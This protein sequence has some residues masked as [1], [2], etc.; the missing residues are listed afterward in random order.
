MTFYRATHFCSSQ[1]RIL[2]IF[3]QVKKNAVCGWVRILWFPRCLI[4]NLI[5]QKQRQS[6]YYF[7][8]IQRFAVNKINKYIWHNFKSLSPPPIQS[9]THMFPIFY[10][11]NIKAFNVNILIYSYIHMWI[12]KCLVCFMWTLS[13]NL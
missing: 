8:L 7:Y 13:F 6:L 4:F 1:I 10:C 3:C 5:L 11:K 12:G 9:S 2:G